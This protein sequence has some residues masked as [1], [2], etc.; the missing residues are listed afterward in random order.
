[1]FENKGAGVNVALR[2]MDIKSCLTKLHI[3]ALH[4]LYSLPNI[5]RVLILQSTRQEW[6]VTN[7]GCM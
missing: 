2:T 4:N 3:K 6:H 5:V 7:T 1:M